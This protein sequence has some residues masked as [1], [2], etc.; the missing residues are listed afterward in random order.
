MQRKKS[1]TYPE[2]VFVALGTQHAMSVRHIVICGLSGCAVFFPHY[3]VNG[4]IVEHTMRVANF[5]TTFVWNISNCA[6][7]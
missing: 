6:K 7:N 1:I 5:S 2:C 4:T 3:L